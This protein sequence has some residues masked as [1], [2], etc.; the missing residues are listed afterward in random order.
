MH[1]KNSLI[2]GIAVAALT[3]SSQGLDD[4]PVQTPCGTCSASTHNNTP[5]Y[6]S[7][8][9]VSWAFFVGPTID[10]DCLEDEEVPCA[11]EGCSFSWHF[12]SGQPGGYEWHEADV[13]NP[14]NPL[15][16]PRPPKRPVGGPPWSTNDTDS[17]SDV[18]YVGSTWPSSVGCGTT[19]SL[20]AA[21]D[22]ESSLALVGLRC[23]SCYLDPEEL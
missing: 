14:N 21:P 3:L 17:V 2:V 22:G 13:D 23:N 8:G 6:N 9:T 10:G 18:S 20:K 1:F 5:G 12:Y 7:T 11:G 19:K 4:P 15:Q 16:N